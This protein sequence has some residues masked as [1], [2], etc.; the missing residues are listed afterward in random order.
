MK[1]FLSMSVLMLVATLQV[2]ASQVGAIPEFVLRTFD[3]VEKFEGDRHNQ[4]AGDFLA[5]L[6]DGS[7]WKVH[8]KDTEK[9]SHWTFGDAVHIRWRYPNYWFKREHQF[10]L[11]NHTRKESVRVMIIDYPAKA[12]AV[13]GYQDVEVDRYIGK[14]H[15]WDKYGNAVKDSKGDY[16]YEEYPVVTYQRDLYLTDGTVWRL[17]RNWHPYT[18][19]KFVYVAANYEADGFHYYLIAGNQ[20]EAVFNEAVRMW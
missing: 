9:F 4:F 8:P 11:Y 19:G 14:R 6:N 12:V 3:G 13:Q 20:R 7:K 10:E 2:L 17:K 16:L 1:K 5:V 15:I 18:E